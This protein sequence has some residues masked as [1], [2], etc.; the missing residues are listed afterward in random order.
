[1]PLQTRL[2]EPIVSN[3]IDIVL[4]KPSVNRKNNIFWL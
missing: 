4:E 3:I 1:L 2:S